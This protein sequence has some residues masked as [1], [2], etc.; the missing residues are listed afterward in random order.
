MRAGAFDYLLS[1]PLDFTEVER[2]YILLGRERQ[3]QQERQRIQDQLTAA[4]AG[5]RLVGIS[6]PVQ[7]LRRLIAKAART[8]APALIVGET[9]TGKELIARLLHELSPRSSAP[10]MA[11]NCN[12][13][14][15]TLL[16]SELFGY[17]K[18][19]FTGARPGPRWTPVRV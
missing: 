16:E 5:S 19:T 6:E 9:G 3:Q 7:N 17:K 11:I 1:P 12:A 8:K 15:A 18:G 2:T 10:F 13:L 4:S 14:P